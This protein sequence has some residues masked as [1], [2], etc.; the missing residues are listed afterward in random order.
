MPGGWLGGGR[1]IAWVADGWTTSLV[2]GSD[3][4]SKELGH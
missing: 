4:C 1:N 3:K 2:I